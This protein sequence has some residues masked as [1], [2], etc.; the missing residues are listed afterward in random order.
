MLNLIVK[1]NITKTSIFHYLILIVFVGLVVVIAFNLDYQK[2]ISL[3]VNQGTKGQVI[4]L[5]Y[6]I[7]ATILSPLN[8]LVL[9]P[10]ALLSFGYWKTVFLIFI[11]TS[12]GSVINFFIA[13]KLGRPVVK[14]LVGT[15]ALDKVDVFTSVA[16]WRAFFVI[17]LL[18][19]NYS[20][21]I[22]Y[23]I[24]LTKLPFSIYL[25]I[26][27]PVYFVWTSFILFMIN[28][29]IEYKNIYSGVLI[30]ISYCLS[31]ATG[32]YVWTKYKNIHKKIK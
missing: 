16:G 3:I 32:F 30:A 4:F 6:M 8:S 13:R 2:L 29:A 19:S 24:G 28:K 1:R 22:S 9:F 27:L 10:I 25:L 26:T 31:L 7:I 14:R 15:K 20:D 21:Y 23:A 17:R 12:I 5:I 11:A 18:G